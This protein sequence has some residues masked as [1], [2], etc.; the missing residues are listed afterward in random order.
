MEGTYTDYKSEP[1]SIES[2]KKLAL[3]SFKK[4]ELPKKT[5]GYF[6][7]IMNKIGWFRQTE[8]LVIDSGVFNSPRSL[9]G[10]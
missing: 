9:R 6:E 7:K 8:V 3:Y 1:I 5:V 10:G 4:P 2:M